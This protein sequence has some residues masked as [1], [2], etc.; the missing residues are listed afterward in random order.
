MNRMNPATRNKDLQRK[1]GQTQ[2]NR[3]DRSSSFPKFFEGYAKP[4]NL[5]RS[6]PYLADSRTLTASARL[7]TAFTAASSNAGTPLE[8]SI[9]TS[10]TNPSVRT[11]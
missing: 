5:A 2:M 4:R 7:L 8:S 1:R 9:T 10:R 6:L 3:M 11:T